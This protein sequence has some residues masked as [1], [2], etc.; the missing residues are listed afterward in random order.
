MAIFILVVN[1]GELFLPSDNQRCS[2]YGYDTR[3]GP[4]NTYAKYRC[5]KLGHAVVMNIWNIGG[6]QRQNYLTPAVSCYFMS[7]SDKVSYLLDNIMLLSQIIA[8]MI[9]TV[10]FERN[11]TPFTIEDILKGELNWNMYEITPPCYIINICILYRLY[12][13]QNDFLQEKFIG[14]THTNFNQATTF[15]WR[16]I[17]FQIWWLLCNPHRSEWPKTFLGHCIGFLHNMLPPPYC[18]TG[19]R[20]V[21]H[22]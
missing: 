10:K 14:Y 1:E 7:L 20:R 17:T 4:F 8:T 15:G 16:N 18:V 6:S 9:S 5:S 11:N 21:N 12:F 13:K 22:S 3:H 2:N 19:P